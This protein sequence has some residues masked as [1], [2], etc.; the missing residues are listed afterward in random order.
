LKE[1]GFYSPKDLE[2][3]DA[4]M[5][6]WQE[7][8]DRGREQHSEHLMTL[9]ENRINV[10]KHILHELQDAL[11]KLDPKM[12]E[13]YVKMVSILRTLSACNTRSKVGILVA[14]DIRLC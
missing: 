7:S 11:S 3:I 2:S 5:T 14:R 6:Q 10:C 1:A 4:K 8:V 12:M 13:T 9:L